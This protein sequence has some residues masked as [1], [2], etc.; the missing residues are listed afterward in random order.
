METAKDKT[1]EGDGIVVSCLK[2]YVKRLQVR[3]SLTPEQEKYRKYLEEFIEND[4]RLIELYEIKND[5][6]EE[7]PEGEPV[8]PGPSDID[9]WIRERE[10][11][12]RYKAVLSVMQEDENMLEFMQLFTNILILAKKVLFMT[13]KKA[14]YSFS[15]YIP[16]PRQSLFNSSVLLDNSLIIMDESDA[17]YQ[18]L[19]DCICRDTAGR[20]FDLASVVEKL[21]IGFRGSKK[22]FPDSFEGSEKIIQEALD[23]V[24][25]LIP[26]NYHLGHAIRFAS[27]TENESSNWM[28]IPRN[29]DR[30]ISSNNSW[31][32]G[33]CE[34]DNVNYLVP[35]IDSDTKDAESIRLFEK[36][37]GLS[38]ETGVKYTTFVMHLTKALNIFR[39]AVLKLAKAEKASEND[40]NEYEL[41]T[42]EKKIMSVLAFLGISDTARNGGSGEQNALATLIETYSGKIY[43]D[44]N[45][46]DSFFMIYTK[47]EDDL[48]L[49]IRAYYVS[50]TPENIIEQM[51]KSG[52]HVMFVSATAGLRS[53]LCNFDIARIEEECGA[54]HEPENE[55]IDAAVCFSHIRG[56]V[57]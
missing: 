8:I 7:D 56:I 15:T 38:L 46:N 50:R 25:D 32:I 26:E 13:T 5:P 40:T 4:N 45:N 21:I 16:G 34:K 53:P 18:D 39:G 57:F 2:E 10:E 35:I 14:F 29:E 19:L 54:I 52:A 51:L 27:I 44:T 6:P 42:Q 17:Q 9:K 55:Q 12:N 47:K 31:Y 49:R 22:K 33:Y 36:E 30:I 37:K 20:N 1:R 48:N 23:K 43:S 3:S 24:R 28:C 11:L 41:M